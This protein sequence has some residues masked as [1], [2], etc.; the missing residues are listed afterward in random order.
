MTV[1][2]F[3][4]GKFFSLSD[5]NAAESLREV[6]DYRGD[7]TLNLK[8]GR[9]VEGYV[10]NCDRGRI[11]L[12]PKD[13]VSSLSVQISEVESIL[14]SGADPAKGKTWED[15]QRKNAAE[16]EQIKAEPIQEV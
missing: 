7:V 5:F 3:V 13:S 16:R 14:F 2:P 11:D 4:Q 8:D 1:E 15:W 12:F 6:V 10:F 9:K